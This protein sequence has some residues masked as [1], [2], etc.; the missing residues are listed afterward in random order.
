ME[1]EGRVDFIWVLVPLQH[2]VEGRI[3]F[4]REER[5]YVSDLSWRFQLLVGG[6]ECVKHGCKI[7]FLVEEPLEK[8]RVLLETRLD[9]VDELTRAWVMFIK[10]L[11]D[12]L[13]VIRLRASV[14]TNGLV[15]PVCGCSACWMDGFP[16][17]S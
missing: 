4:H 3:D 12:G 11:G 5:R 13:E 6:D 1:L 15:R 8:V 7:L 17:L 2:V 14:V 16:C 9:V 10:L